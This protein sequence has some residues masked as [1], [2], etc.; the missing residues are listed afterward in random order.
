M[1]PAQKRIVEHLESGHRLD[2]TH[3]GLVPQKNDGYRAG[4]ALHHVTEKVIKEHFA[5][6]LSYTYV[7]SP[8]FEVPNQF[9]CLT[10]HVDKCV[11]KHTLLSTA[12]Y[13]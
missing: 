3:R 10:E 4:R 5:G 1:S 9:I 8:K 2:C 6:R 13:L 11:G 7:R 12:I